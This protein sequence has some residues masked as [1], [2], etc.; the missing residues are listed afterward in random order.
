MR[1]SVVTPSFRNSRWLKLCIAS[2]ADQGTDTEHIIQDNCSDD[3]TVDWLRTDNRVRLFVE[4][5]SGMY[6]AIN[7]GLRRSTGDVLMYLNCDEQLLPGALEAVIKH[8]ESNPH[9]EV[10]FA[11]AVIVNE[12]GDYVCSRKAQIPSRNH[13]KVAQLPTFSCAT[14]FRRSLVQQRQIFFDTQWRTISDATW[15]LRILASGVQTGVLRQF[16]SAFTDRPGNLAMGT[17]ARSERE[18][19]SKMAPAWVRCF[20]PALVGVH[21]LRRLLS[22]AYSQTSFQYAIYSPDNLNERTVHNVANPTGVW[23]NRLG[24]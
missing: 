6:D 23:R 14:F 3:G 17:T 22:G 5:D 4:K 24:A 12:K 8:F 20:K 21:R 13:I 19:L 9:L 15:V 2:V 16:T 1:V 10:V 11:D 18:A 7:R